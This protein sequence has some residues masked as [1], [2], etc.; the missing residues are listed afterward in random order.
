MGGGGSGETYPTLLRYNHECTHMG[1]IYRHYNSYSR[2]GYIR[3]TVHDIAH[4]LL[5]L[6]R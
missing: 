6:D 1:Y 3:E 4:V 5:T 2:E